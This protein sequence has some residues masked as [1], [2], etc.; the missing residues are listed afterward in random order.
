MTTSGT[1]S[2]LIAMGLVLMFLGIGIV[3]TGGDTNLDEILFV[4]GLVIA[5][6]GVVVAL[7]RATGAR[8]D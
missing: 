1:A 8:S 3:T 4:A 5:T 6:G 7:R 2:L